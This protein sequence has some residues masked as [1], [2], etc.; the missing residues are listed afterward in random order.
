M[1]AIPESDAATESPLPLQVLMQEY[2]CDV[3]SRDAAAREETRAKLRPVTEEFPPLD[4]SWVKHAP[5]YEWRCVA[6]DG[7]QPKCREGGDAPLT[8]LMRTEHRLVDGALHGATADTLD[9]A[10]WRARHD[11]EC[12]GRFV[13]VSDETA[14][15][16]ATRN[17]GFFSLADARADGGGAGADAS[18]DGRGN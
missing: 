7:A 16:A 11:A 14:R 8:K 17:N 9:K 15:E 5:G 12:N 13:Q 3:L 18:D 10:H 1:G 6:Q 4:D 2:Q